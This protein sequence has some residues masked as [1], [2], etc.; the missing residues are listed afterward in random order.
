MKRNSNDLAAPLIGLAAVFA[1]LFTLGLAVVVPANL[2]P[3][4]GDFPASVAT[5]SGGARAVAVEVAIV[6]ARIEVIG[7][8]R[9]PAA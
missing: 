9:P 6:P 5:A 3:A 2:A 1:T 8:R 7:V 4:A